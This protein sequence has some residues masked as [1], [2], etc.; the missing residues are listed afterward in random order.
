[1]LGKIYD[2]EVNKKENDDKKDSGGEEEVKDDKLKG[3]EEVEMK[4]TDQ[5]N[6]SVANPMQKL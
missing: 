3:E 5:L 2:G 1:M 4:S 6:D